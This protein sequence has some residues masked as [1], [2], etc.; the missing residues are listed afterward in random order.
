MLLF[1]IYGRLVDFD[2]I[3]LCLFFKYLM[4]SVKC[5]YLLNS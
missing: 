3:E 4:P 5:A 1:I 2:F